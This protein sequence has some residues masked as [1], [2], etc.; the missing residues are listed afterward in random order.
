MSTICCLVAL[1]CLTGC[2]GANPFPS[3]P[4]KPVPI[5]EALKEKR[6]WIQIAGYG[7]EISK[8]MSVQ[9]VWDF[10]GDGT[11]TVHNAPYSV[12]LKD[13]KDMSNEEIIAYVDSEY[14]KK[15]DIKE[16]FN[17]KPAPYELI[18]TTD[19][20]GNK[21]KDETLWGS[22]LQR[23]V[24]DE[25]L[26]LDMGPEHVEFIKAYSQTVYN[27]RYC[28]LGWS[29]EAD[30][31]NVLNPD[32]TRKVIGKFFITSCDEG[33]PGFAL[34]TPTTQGITVR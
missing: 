8:D 2:G 20:T 33:Y 3:T 16:D 15:E 26:R 11:V 21:T 28:G 7:P 14:I 23:N 6:L 18:V 12:E 22:A 34:D 10:H 4:K 30:V 31:P 19:A 25:K 9:A 5:S 24:L 32:T 1:T 13:L 17:P 29:G 27:T